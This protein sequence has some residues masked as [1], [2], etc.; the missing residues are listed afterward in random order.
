MNECT[1]ISQESEETDHGLKIDNRNRHLNKQDITTTRLKVYETSHYAD[2][3]FYRWIE[4][5]DIVPQSR[6]DIK[7]N[8]VYIKKEDV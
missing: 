3:F 2:F 1:A 6:S 8:K 4:Y 5:Q 7:Y